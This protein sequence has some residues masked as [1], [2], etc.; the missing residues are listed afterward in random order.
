M[1]SMN[2]STN[3]TYE[4]M[5]AH[6]F[7]EPRSKVLSVGYRDESMKYQGGNSYQ[8][9]NVLGAQG[10]KLVSVHTIDPTEIIG[11]FMREV[12]S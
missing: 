4:Y 11:V 6:L 7:F 2:S 5:Q 3:V 12:R 10:W 1:Q 9:A 8:D